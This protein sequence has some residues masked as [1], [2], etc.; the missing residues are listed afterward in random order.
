MVLGPA[1]ETP[2]LASSSSPPPPVQLRLYGGKHQFPRP[3][4][5]ERPTVAEYVE[6]Q[7]GAS[8]CA[9]SAEHV[10]SEGTHRHRP[11]AAVVVISRGGADHHSGG[12][13]D[14]QDAPPHPAVETFVTPEGSWL[15][16]EPADE[17]DE[18]AI[19]GDF[20]NGDASHHKS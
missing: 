8:H 20:T 11:A 10:R 17:N 18:G 3:L 7:G 4:P 5:Q 15:A 13:N 2:A 1:A 9:G 16:S 6:N 19:G 14:G 12:R